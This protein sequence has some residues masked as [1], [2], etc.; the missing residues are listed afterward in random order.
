MEAH[1][2]FQT[3]T[4]I[5]EHAPLAQNVKADC[6][7]AVCESRNVPELRIRLRRYGIPQ[8][9]QDALAAFRQSAW[10]VSVRMRVL[11]GLQGFI[12][13]GVGL[14]WLVG[15]VGAVIVVGYGLYSLVDMMQTVHGT[16]ILILGALIWIS[17]SVANKG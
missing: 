14:A 5:L 12:A 9:V 1:P 16:L 8:N 6:W 10:P 17:V 11:G 15:I 2:M 13:F 4:Q 7:D 3:L